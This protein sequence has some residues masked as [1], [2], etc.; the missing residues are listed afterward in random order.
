MFSNNLK[1]AKIAEIK[2]SK[3]KEKNNMINDKRELEGTGTDKMLLTRE[4]FMKI[5]DKYV[6]PEFYND[7]YSNQFEKRLNA[8]D[9]IGKVIS[10]WMDDYDEIFEDH[11]GEFFD[12]DTIFLK[13]SEK[14][15]IQDF[16]YHMELENEEVLYNLM[17]N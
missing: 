13:D 3:L 1:R 8:G 15:L 12:I 4:Q 17:N 16:F 7:L 10:D 2:N 9:A 6:S 5:I 11:N 14:T